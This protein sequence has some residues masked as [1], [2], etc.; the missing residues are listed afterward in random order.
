MREVIFVPDS[1]YHPIG[2]PMSLDVVQA[3]GPQDAN[4]HGVQ[5]GEPYRSDAR[6]NVGFDDAP[7]IRPLFERTHVH[8]YVRPSRPCNAFDERRDTRIAVAEQ[9]VTGI[10]YAGE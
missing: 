10:K 2:K 3:N 1:V 7:G 6:R 5:L 8:R 9:N 4:M